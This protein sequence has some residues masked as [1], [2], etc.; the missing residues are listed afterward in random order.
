MKK[1]TIQDFLTIIR[2]K[3]PREW[4]RGQ[5]MW[6]LLCELGYKEIRDVIWNMEDSNKV[7]PFYLDSNIPAFLAFLAD[8]VELE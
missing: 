6:N 1:I 5:T 3:G 2:A 8:Y 7:D 4:R